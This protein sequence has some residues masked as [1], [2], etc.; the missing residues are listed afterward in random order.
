M[1]GAHRGAQRSMPPE[2]QELREHAR[3]RRW[4]VTSKLKGHA[5]LEAFGRSVGVLRHEHRYHDPGA[6]ADH[7]ATKRALDRG[8]L[9]VPLYQKTVNPHNVRSWSRRG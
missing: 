1:A 9:I 5:R 2:L 4:A 8:D 3:R 7:R 6:A